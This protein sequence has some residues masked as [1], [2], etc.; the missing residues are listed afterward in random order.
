MEFPDDRQV[1]VR[2]AR[3]IHPA[4]GSKTNCPFKNQFVT[5]PETVAIGRVI[6]SRSFLVSGP[7]LKRRSTIRHHQPGGLT[8]AKPSRFFRLLS[9][10]QIV[11][12]QTVSVDHARVPWHHAG[13]K[14]PG[15]VTFQS[16][17]ATTHATISNADI[18]IRHTDDHRRKTRWTTGDRPHVA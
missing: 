1:R 15:N 18:A 16:A 2:P 10:H 7:H 8:D 6:G 17:D 9:L 12:Q 3:P 14:W 5:D 4:Q 13:A 11:D